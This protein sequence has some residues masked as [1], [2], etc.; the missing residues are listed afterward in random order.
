MNHD[1]GN[2][3]IL[4]E[5]HRG[6]GGGIEMPES[7]LAGF[8]FGWLLGAR[9]E[10]DVNRTRDGVIVSVHDD[11]LDRIIPELPESMKGRKISAMTYEQLRSLESGN[12]ACPGQHIP[13]LNELFERMKK[14]PEKHMILDYKNVDLRELAELIAAYGVA[15]Q[16]TFASCQPEKCREIKALLPEIRI[17]VWIGGSREEILGTFHS[18]AEQSFSGFEEIQLHLNDR[19]DHTSG[20][21]RYQLTAD[22]IS[23]ALKCT[24]DAGVL[25]QV[26]PWKFEKDDLFRILELGIRSFAVDYPIHFVR[27]C[28][29]YFA[30]QKKESR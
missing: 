28:A 15:G 6:G 20:E 19:P 27:W 12:A 16:L 2:R 14:D 4:W 3:I 5:A 11:T 10:A 29:E 22:D 21:W 8:E 26:L 24:A 1:T 7:C 30:G 25:L 17:K 18:L 23:G 9:P 13:S